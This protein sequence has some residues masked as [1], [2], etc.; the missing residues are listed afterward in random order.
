MFAALLRSM[1][2]VRGMTQGELAKEAKVSRMDV[3]RMER[4]VGR[5]PTDEEVHRLM[6]ALGGKPK[7]M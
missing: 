4:G 1:R 7:A 5:L 2:Q 3:S 6:L